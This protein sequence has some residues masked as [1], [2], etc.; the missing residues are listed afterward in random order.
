M[1]GH[2]FPPHEIEVVACDV[3]A[4]VIPGDQDAQGVIGEGIAEKNPEGRL[5]TA[6]SLVIGTGNEGACL[7]SGFVERSGGFDV[8]S[9]ANGS[10]G[11]GEVRSFV[12]VELAY[13]LSPQGAEVEVLAVAGS[14]RP[15]ASKH[16]VELISEAA[17]GDA[18]YLAG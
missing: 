14:Y 4:R 15:S 6:I 11:K 13:V 5:D 7:R 12:D 10:S 2:P 8:D 17:N 3:F 9:R 16:L 1:R 18:G